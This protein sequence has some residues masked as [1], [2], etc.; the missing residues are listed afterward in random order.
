[1]TKGYN[2]M[3]AQR[4]QTQQTTDHRFP[5]ELTCIDVSK[6]HTYSSVAVHSSCHPV[7]TFWNKIKIPY[8]LNVTLN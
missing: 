6:P 4:I 5:I 2:Y 1:M 8:Y 7:I 3:Y